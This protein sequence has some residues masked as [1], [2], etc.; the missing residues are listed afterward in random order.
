M[1]GFFQGRVGLKPTDKLDLMAS[2]SIANADKKSTPDWLYNDYGYE[3]D[4]TAT[5][6]ITW[7]CPTRWAQTIYSPANIL[8]GSRMPMPYPM[9]IC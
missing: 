5:C 8:E 4:L 2:I 7:R 1:P 3:F 6:K 9:I